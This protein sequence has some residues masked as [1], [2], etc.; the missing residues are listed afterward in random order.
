[1]VEVV[2]VAQLQYLV[3]PMLAVSN[4]DVATVI[5]WHMRTILMSILK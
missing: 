2:V 4:N 1:V 5:A 3:A